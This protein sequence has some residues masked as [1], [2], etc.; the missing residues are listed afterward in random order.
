[1]KKVI[2]TL[3]FCVM[4]AFDSKA[5][6]NILSLNRDSV[7]ANTMQG[8]NLGDTLSIDSD[9]ATTW[10][11]GNT[12]VNHWLKYDAGYQ[13]FYRSNVESLRI[14]IA[15]AYAD[16]APRQFQLQGS[17]NSRLADSVW[18]TLPERTGT[19]TD[20]IL[21]ISRTDTSVWQA[22]EFY[23][24]VRYR[25]YRL[26]F[27][28]NH[29]QNTTNKVAISEWELYER[30][31]EIEV[32]DRGP[33]PLHY[34]T[35]LSRANSHLGRYGGQPESIQDTFYVYSTESDSTDDDS[36]LIYNM[37]KEQGYL[38]RVRTGDNANSDSTKL[39]VIFRSGNHDRGQPLIP[40]DTLNITAAGDYILDINPF[41][42]QKHWDL[43]FE[44]TAG[45]LAVGQGTPDSSEIKIFGDIDRDRY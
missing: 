43:K 24:P 22:W 35:R 36:T 16:S 28:N 7:S 19:I 15:G 3:L 9:T 34:D 6:L 10:V 39:R 4:F 26:L 42:P 30:H 11:S 17:N 32:I 29:P 5:D 44:S 20:T 27:L 41:R 12:A 13:N 33:G 40:V 38:L 31:Q 14:F 18:V 45:S 8:A 1:M 2:F 25:A 21:T 23:N 37:W